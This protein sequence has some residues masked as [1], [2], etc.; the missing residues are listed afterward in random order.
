MKA[1]ASAAMPSGHS[2]PLGVTR[3]L[4]LFTSGLRYE[5]LPPATVD[6]AKRLLL[7]G[8]GCL[9]AGA[10][11]ADG[12]NATAMVRRL[13]G[14]AQATL[15][16]DIKPAS[17]RDAAFVNGICLYSVG[18]N[19]IHKP[20]GSHP[21]GSIIPVVLAVGEWRRSSGAALLAAM[22]AG[23]EV[24]GRVGRAI[25]PSHR[26][27]GFHPTG[28]CG[29]FGAAAAAGSL[30]ALDESATASALG[31]AGS[32]AAGLYECHH[33][34]TSTMIFHAGRAAQNGVEA[35]L[36]IEAGFT[37][38][39][40]VLE[41][42]KGFFRATTDRYDAAKAMRDLGQ[43]F[44][45]DATSFRPYF[46][47]NSTIAASGAAAQI[48]DEHKGLSPED[49]QEVVVYCNLVP[50]N[51]NADPDPRTLLAARLSLPFNI[52][53]VLVKRA[54]VS[55]DLDEETLHE[56]RIRNLLPRIRVIVDDQMTRYGARVRVRTRD[57]RT[58]ERV[59]REPRG[60][61]D[62][63]LLWDDVVGKF[64]R[65][66]QPF[67]TEVSARRVIEAVADLE[68]TDASGFAETLRGAMPG[69]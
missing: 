46:G 3:A 26:E 1:A 19:D 31:I 15:Y 11:A 68:S 5:H 55:T 58:M 25:R 43:R 10:Q 27:R 34:G 29:T 53:L 4:A 9:L 16:T 61:E 47:C 50:A 60:S 52:A 37:G 45:I 2:Q 13:G 54:V 57:G 28:T 65:L 18:L 33:D 69:K 42:D 56:P 59:I 51:D 64:C 36:L 48:L 62:N 44:E 32:Q 23:Y 30:L 6:M 7:D 20:A 12:R 14:A 41:G 38:P 49:V 39:A 17:V 40:T 21:A 8:I 35:A 24:I 63:P 67:M 66:V 22:T